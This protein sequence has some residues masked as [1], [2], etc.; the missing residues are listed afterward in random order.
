MDKATQNANELI[1][2]LNLQYN[3]ARQAAITTE[4]LEIVGGAEALRSS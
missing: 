4:M 1:K 2:D 3:N